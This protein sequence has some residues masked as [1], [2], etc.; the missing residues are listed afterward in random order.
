MLDGVARIPRG[1]VTTYGRITAAIEHPRR[2]R[3]VGLALATADE[4]GDYPCHRVVNREGVLSGGWSFGH[5]DIMRLLLDDEG[6]PFIG[7]YTVDL[8]P[9]LWEPPGTRRPNPQERPGAQ[10]PSVTPGLGPCPD[11]T[12][13]RAPGEACAPSR[14]ERRR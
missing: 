1:R 9:C 3:H 8:D 5:P 2:A 13:R 10:P 6:I 12:R 4:A 7:E 14:A 11:S